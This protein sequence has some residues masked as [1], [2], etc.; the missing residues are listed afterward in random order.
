[1]PGREPGLGF[2]K[3]TILERVAGLSKSSGNAVC[4]NAGLGF[5]LFCGLAIH[6][7]MF[8]IQI[9]AKLIQ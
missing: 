3:D 1:M 7:I 2:L 5:S 9:K 8:L 6:R 4:A